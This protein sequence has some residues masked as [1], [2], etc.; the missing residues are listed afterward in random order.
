MHKIFKSKITYNNTCQ[1]S[2]IQINTS[3]SLKTK[4]DSSLGVC[5]GAKRTSSY[6]MSKRFLKKRWVCSLADCESQAPI[7][8][9]IGFILMQQGLQRKRPLCLKL[10]FTCTNDYGLHLKNIILH[11]T[12]L[13]NSFSSRLFSDF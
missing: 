11:L 1:K 13:E 3:K 5:L 6:L 8:F 2:C 10:I 9:E 4:F 12:F 7:T